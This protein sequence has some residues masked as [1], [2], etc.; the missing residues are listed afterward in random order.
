M[1]A[2]ESSSDRM[3]DEEHHDNTAQTKRRLGCVKPRTLGLFFVVSIL[4][5]FLLVSIMLGLLLAGKLASVEE[6]GT[7]SQNGENVNLKSGSKVS[8]TRKGSTFD[9]PELDQVCIQCDPGKGVQLDLVTLYPVNNGTKPLCCKEYTASEL[10]S[11]MARTRT[12]PKFG[13]TLSYDDYGCPPVLDGS[14]MPAGLVFLDFEGSSDSGLRWTEY[15]GSYLKGEVTLSR[16]ASYTMLTVPEDGLYVVYS[17][18]EFRGSIDSDGDVN[19]VNIQVHSLVRYPNKVVQMHRFSLKENDIKKSV[20]TAV[21]Q[22]N[23]QD[24]IFVAVKDMSYIYDDSKINR[25]GLYKLH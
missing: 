15:D 6:P 17:D 1:A 11:D 13:L 23:A 9:P 7:D 4:I 19:K 10:D 25:F 5:N 2:G 12:S 22:L 14:V 24:A 8:S 20:A 18:L 3:V 21:L 16:I